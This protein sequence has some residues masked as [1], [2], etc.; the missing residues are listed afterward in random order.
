MAADLFDLGVI[1]A[2]TGR[3]IYPEGIPEK[4]E[5]DFARRPGRRWLVVPF[6]IRQATTACPR[7]TGD[8][9]VLQ[10]FRKFVIKY[11]PTQASIRPNGKKKLLKFQVTDSSP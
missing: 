5:V 4:L 8:L 1:P 9:P 10:A 3:T 7:L 11:T 6:E 2:K